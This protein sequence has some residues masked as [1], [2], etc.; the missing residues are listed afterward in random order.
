MAK[1]IHLSQ[2]IPLPIR[3][4]SSIIQLKSMSRHNL[5]LKVGLV[6]I[7][8]HNLNQLKL[9]NGTRLPVNKFTNNTIEAT[10]I[11]VKFKGKDM[12]ILRISLKSLLLYRIPIRLS[13]SSFWSVLY[14]PWC[15]ISHKVNNYKYME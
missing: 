12:L 10:I 14:S 3:M 4:K 6:I 8:L 9:C 13:V 11:I 1:Y 7:I 2:S 5:Q 15:S